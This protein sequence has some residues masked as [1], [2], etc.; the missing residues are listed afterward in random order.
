MVDVYQL[1]QHITEGKTDQAVNLA[2]KLS[3]E[4]VQLQANITDRA[5]KEESISYVLK[6][7]IISIH[8]S[9]GKRRISYFWDFV[10]FHGIFMRFWDFNK[11]SRFQWDFEIFIA[12]SG[13][14][15][16]SKDFM[17]FNGISKISGILM[18]FLGFQ[19]FSSDFTGFG[20]FEIRRFPLV[21]SPYIILYFLSIESRLKSIVIMQRSVINTRNR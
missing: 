15:W 20:I 14:Q 8:F 2:K 18:G 7:L 16:D 6:K 12:F 21:I 13:F 5:V 9:R 1:G 17:D 3:Q 4:R 11:I 10:D 19:G